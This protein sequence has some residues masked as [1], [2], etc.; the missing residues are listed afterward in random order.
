VPQADRAL[1]ALPD[2][3]SDEAAVFLADILPTGFAAVAR[4]GVSS[5]DTVVVVVQPASGDALQFLKAGIM[6][7]PDVLVVTKADLGDVA[8]RAR[9]ELASALQARPAVQIVPS[10][11]P[12][13]VRGICPSWFAG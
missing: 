13:T 5:G 8:M 2:E 11:T 12:S 6:E 4:G 3:V 9:R 7:V 10:A 1:R